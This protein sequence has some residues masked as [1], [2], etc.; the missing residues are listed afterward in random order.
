MTER[1]RMDLGGEWSMRHFL[2]GE[3]DYKNPDDVKSLPVISAQVPGN[4]E[5]DLMR[6]GLIEDPFVGT[7]STQLRPYEFHT[8]CYERTFTTPDFVNPDLVF[9]GLDCY[10]DIWL[11]GVKIAST[12]NALIPHRFP[13][14]QYL[15]AAGE[16]NML[17][18][19][20]RSPLNAVRDEPMDTWYRAHAFGIEAVRIRKPSHCFG[21]DIMPRIISAGIWRPVYIEERLPNDI[22]MLYF[23]VESCDENRADIHCFYQFT[24]DLKVLEGL[25]MRI[26][27]TCGDSRFI[28]ERPLTFTWN[29]FR[30]FVQ[31]PK[32]WWPRGYGEQNLYDVHV[33]VL[34]HGKVIADK[35]T[36][37]GIRTVVLDN[38]MLNTKEHPG[39]FNFIIN[40][41]PVF[42]KGSNWVPADALHSRDA[43][44]IPRILKLFTEM[45]C[46]MLRCWGGNVYEPQLFYDICDREGIMIWQDFSMACGAYPQ[47]EE[48]LARFR[49]EAEVVVTERRQ[50]PSLVLWAGDNENDCGSIGWWGNYRDPAKNRLTREVIP[51]VLDRLDGFRPYIPSSPYI[52]PDIVALKGNERI[53]PEQHLW[54]ARDYYKAPFYSNNNAC[55]ASET[56]YHGCPAA[57]SIRKFTHPEYN[58]PW[59]GNPEWGIHAT[60]PIPGTSHLDGRITM[61]SNQMMEFYGVIPDTLEEYVP[62]SQ[63]VQAQAKKFFVELFRQRRPFTSG[64]LWWNMMDGWPQISDAIVDYYFTKKLA[65][66]YLKQSHQDICLILCE[67]DAW[68]CR[69]IVDNTTRVERKGHYKVLDGDTRECLLEGDFTAKANQNCFLANIRAPRSAK[70]LF[71]MEWML[72]GEEG[73]HYNHYLLGT[74]PFDLAT[75]RK[76]MDIIAKTTQK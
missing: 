46:N 4:Y 13:V 28:D 35:H 19:R 12:D 33:E 40:G 71:L 14:A 65:F 64:I 58:W 54:G 55:F 3:F 18:V 25:S 67:P 21:W 2:E 15:R 34:H 56:G 61:M 52:T 7:N 9:E 76:W 39:R 8:F 59:K 37:L 29:Q 57:E 72:D 6:A 51:Q 48:F 36:T 17:F 11:N 53:G 70:R 38:T 69:L 26:T 49:R 20:L 30:I 60:D 50:H 1:R 31:N 74:P 5:L 23:A 10:A 24:T 43:E 66:D 47:D 62:A 44:R 27:G 32:L 75:C 41:V 45:N 73:L 16:E 22:T 63:F 42:A 68:N